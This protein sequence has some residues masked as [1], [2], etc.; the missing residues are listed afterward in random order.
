MSNDT[1][2]VKQNVTPNE[3]YIQE[4]VFNKKIVNVPQPYDYNYNNKTL[5]MHKIPEMSISDMYGEKF[6]DIPLYIIEQIRD[7]ITTL[8]TNNIEYPDITGYNFIEHQDKVWI[9]DFGHASYN[10]NHTTYD[11]FIL[12]FINGH[13]DWNPSYK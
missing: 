13:N 4:M 10:S 11:P 2:Y 5:I 12:K 3:F 1:M 9:I 6:S 7:I 8:Y